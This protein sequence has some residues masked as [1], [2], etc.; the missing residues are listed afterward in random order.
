MR[1]PYSLQSACIRTLVNSYDVKIMQT[2]VREMFPNYDIYQRT[3]FPPNIPIQM[4]DAA[5]QVVKDI[6]AQDMFLDMLS[7]MMRFQESG[8]MGRK[9]PV[10]GLREI[11][12]GLDELG[13][14]F[15]EELKLFYEDSTVRKT[16]NWGAL[17][18]NQIYTLT[19]LRLDIKGNT[20]LV[21]K[22][23]RTKMQ[24]IYRQIYQL[25]QTKVELREGRIWQW[26]GDGGLAAFFL[27]G[28]QID[29]VLAAMEILH[30]LFLYN[31]CDSII[32]ENIDLRIAV[33][34]G[35]CSYSSNFE[36]LKKND[37]IKKI[38]EQEEKN[39]PPGS[40]SISN[41][42]YVNLS[43]RLANE[44]IPI[45]NSGKPSYHI[46]SIQWEET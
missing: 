34:T 13:Y 46:Y 23:G 26:E 44:F 39:T 10:K 3:G 40:I 17:I 6:C 45:M 14:L 29:T 42:V 37:V 30:A 35:T 8:Y 7:V 5:R 24:H 27:P 33:H 22:Y 25:V 32:E 11:L 28:N 43:S 18:E 2:M 15:D 41:R 36:E 31:L 1:V 19:F 12:N 38:I 21:R 9:Y 4:M 20:K 16:A